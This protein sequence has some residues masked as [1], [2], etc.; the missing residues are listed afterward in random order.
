MY[1]AAGINPAVS[2]NTWGPTDVDGAIPHC[3]VG[4]ASDGQ[5]AVAA[6][7]DTPGS[8]RAGRTES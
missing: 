2:E 3:M 8:L 7:G 5:A 6:T 4:M 1:R